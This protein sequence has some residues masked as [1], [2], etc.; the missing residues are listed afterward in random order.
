MADAKPKPEEREALKR[1]AAG[2]S[3]R[4]SEFRRGLAAAFGAAVAERKMTAKS[5]SKQARVPVGQ[6]R[7]LLRPEVG[8]HLT[9]RSI[10]R[11]AEVLGL[12]VAVGLT[13][14][15]AP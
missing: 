3:R 10:F 8:G 12:D 9:L 11:A 15:G 2:G 4:E 5:L 6:I 13:G 14:G 7:R 1:V